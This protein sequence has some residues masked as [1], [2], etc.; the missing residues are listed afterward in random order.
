MLKPI[1]GKIWATRPFYKMLVNGWKAYVHPLFEEQLRRLEEQ[2]AALVKKDPA[3]YRNEPAAKL[4][5][6]IRRY[7]LEIIPRDPG[8]AEF[9]LGNTLGPDNRHWFRAKFHER[10]RVFYR[11]SSLERIFVYDSVNVERSLRKSGSKTDPCRVFRALLEAGDPPG[12]M[13]D[14]LRRVKELEP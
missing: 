8:A 11:F 14:L 7:I 2:V 3:R 1:R 9:R 5:G 10:Y 13:Q 4:L 6:T 12:S